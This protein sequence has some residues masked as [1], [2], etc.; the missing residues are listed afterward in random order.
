MTGIG[1]VVVG[2]RLVASIVTSETRTAPAPAASFVPDAE[3][4]AIP[5]TAVH[6]D[7]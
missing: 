5:L 6:L 2:L 3:P 1:T 4:Q 7:A